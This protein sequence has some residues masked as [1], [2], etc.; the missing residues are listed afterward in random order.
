MSKK[1]AGRSAG[2]RYDFKGFS[3]LNI[4][5]WLDLRVEKDDQENE[6]ASGRK[7]QINTY[8]KTLFRKIFEGFGLEFGDEAI[9]VTAQRKKY[10]TRTGT[11]IYTQKGFLHRFAKVL[12]SSVVPTDPAYM[13]INKTLGLLVPNMD[14]N[15]EE[16]AFR[17]AF[18]EAFLNAKEGE[19][20]C[21]KEY[22]DGFKT[23]IRRVLKDSKTDE[24]DIKAIMWILLVSVFPNWLNDDDLISQDNTDYSKSLILFIQRS[25]EWGKY[26]PSGSDGSHNFDLNGKYPEVTSAIL[27]L[28]EQICRE[29]KKYGRLIPMEDAEKGMPIE[30]P[31]LENDNVEDKDK[32][33]LSLKTLVEELDN[34]SLMLTGEGG[35]GKTYAL[36]HTA[37]AIL[38]EIV[39]MK[40]NDRFRKPVLP[41]YVPLSKLSGEFSD[42]IEHYLIDKLAV[43]IGKKYDEVKHLFHTWRESLP[44]GYVVF[45]CDGFNEVV[46]LEMQNKLISE[47][48]SLAG[49]SGLRFVITSRY[50]MSQTFS[51][52]SGDLQNNVFCAY[53]MRALEDEYVKSYTRKA[54]KA[55][56]VDNDTI[57]AVIRDELCDRDG[58]VDPIYKNPMG[59]IMFC[60]IH[61]R[62]N[63]STASSKFFVR[64]K[65]TGELLHNFIFCIRAAYRNTDAVHDFLCYLGFG[66]NT[67][68]VFVIRRNQFRE[69]FEEFK[70]KTICNLTFDDL[71]GMGYPKDM[72]KQSEDG[73]ISFKHQNYRD[74]F[75]AEYLK[76]IIVSENHIRINNEIGVDK[77][78]PRE[79][80]VILS[81]ILGEYRY[82]ENG[83]VIASLLEDT[84]VT[85]KLSASAVA[86][87]LQLVIIGREN[88]LSTFKFSGLDLTRTRLNGVI[89]SKPGK[90]KKPHGADFEGCTLSDG[91]LMPVGHA[92][93][94]Q[95]V[96]YLEKRFLLTLGKGRLCVFDMEKGI[97]Y[98]V[99]DYPNSAVYAAH[100]LPD[101]RFVSGD[102]DGVLA[103]WE[104][105][106]NGGI[107]ETKKLEN[108]CL[109]ETV[110]P[111]Q[112]RSKR[113]QCAIQDM[114]LYNGKLV[115]A[116]K[117]GDVFAT[118]TELKSMRRLYDLSEHA[119]GLFDMCKT[120]LTGSVLCLSYGRKLF[121]SDGES[122]CET[123][124]PTLDGEYIYDIAA[125]SANG[126]RGIV[127]NL[128]GAK[129]S[130]VMLYDLGKESFLTLAD[131]VHSVSS[132]GFFGYTNFSPAFDKKR[133]VYLA[134][135][136][137]DTEEEAGLYLFTFNAEYDLDKEEYVGLEPAS[138]VAAIYGS[139]HTMA[140]LRALRFEYNGISYVTT[141]SMDRS[142]E[143]LME[144]TDYNLIY[145][146]PGHTDGVTSLAVIDEN[147][148]YTAHYC[149]E[150]C[151]WRKQKNGEW[152]CRLTVKP[153]S[154]KWVWT[155]KHLARTD[156]NYMVAGSYD[157]NISVT[158]DLTGEIRILDS[159]NG[160]VKSLDFID[161]NTIVTAHDFKEKDGAHFE[162]CVL[163][164]FPEAGR[165]KSKKYPAPHS[166]SRYVKVYDGSVY[167][168]V[169]TAENAHPVCRIFRFDTEFLR[170]MKKPTINWNSPFHTIEGDGDRIQIRDMD[171]AKYKGKTL[172]ACGGN[173]DLFYFEVWTDEGASASVLE[174]PEAA[175]LD[176]GSSNRFDGI[177]AVS[178]I[179]HMNVLYLLASSYNGS[180]YTYKVD[181]LDSGGVALEY[182]S[183]C[184]NS[185]KVLDMQCR[186]SMVYVSL[187]TG[188]VCAYDIAELVKQPEYFKSE[189]DLL[190]RAVSGFGVV[191]VDLNG[192]NIPLTLMNNL[193]YYANI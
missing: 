15:D 113:E 105:S 35:C 84:Q 173:I 25:S 69:Y 182:I 53:R 29:E 163:R 171:I 118:D 154:D 57:D 159:C 191:D 52:L 169:N 76:S 1:Q 92:G 9:R 43:R 67:A 166:F 80:L 42:P 23:F 170:N 139:R 98:V 56:G 77:H 81:E 40:Q 95:E 50:D 188:E 165:V 164:I 51:E 2:G 24:P 31:D 176:V 63:Y 16:I 7:K 162:L 102:S 145:H 129:R 6:N 5:S 11:E 186:G 96:L 151:R 150:V 172:Y 65:K 88:D 132:Q 136:L 97:P 160:W 18:V 108:R 122:L 49:G 175:F 87:L 55:T 178:F 106:I 99:S 38:D 12:D 174:V 39:S 167:V 85:R 27:D 121:F 59:L 101:N 147:T 103:L 157:H 183:V 79:V 112:S 126:C 73:R 133:A 190:F 91:T 134:T 30:I 44:S 127:I 58:N 156:V 120:E 144:G 17:T 143:I 70:N 78:I 3:F 161:D 117:N 116:C 83:G 148:I 94:P 131:R 68:G 41:L 153:H 187:F 62:E 90:D 72:L 184:R 146:L 107:F 100:E 60:G 149:G 119:G 19:I 124:L 86:L 125:V 140:V 135:E 64:P 192:N 137:N 61:T 114:V 179:E 142:V 180:V 189:K 21:N 168:I 46:S 123:A 155:V 141:T 13:N 22:E 110:S 28:A 115:F 45:L 8:V 54:L 4:V 26:Y 32:Q 33:L 158:D 177:S 37:S 104:Y 75:A 93:A 109:T 82:A 130:R 36:L 74:Y 193:K 48:K 128:R 71:K 181:V 20:L 138:N 14:P 10:R 34:R 185:D 111:K 152:K 89:L 47:I 66:M